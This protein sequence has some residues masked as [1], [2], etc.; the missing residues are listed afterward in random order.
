M[1]MGDEHTTFSLSTLSYICIQL[2]T[3]SHPL[4]LELYVLHAL[5]KVVSVQ[6]DDLHGIRL[7]I[8]VMFWIP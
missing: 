3:N 1:A 6:F 5:L 7:H 2:H 8:N 4:N